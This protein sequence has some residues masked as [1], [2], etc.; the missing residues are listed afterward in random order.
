[1]KLIVSKQDGDYFAYIEDEKHFKI[2][3]KKSKKSGGRK[4]M[5]K[6]DP[7]KLRNECMLESYGD[8]FYFVFDVEEQSEI[9]SK[10]SKSASKK[11]NRKRNKTK[12]SRN[13][14]AKIKKWQTNR[15]S[16]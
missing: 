2:V 4:D 8:D 16:I 14:Y 12:A 6:P 5:K 3:E 10:R 13:T 7:K 9:Y 15:R 1:M 11:T